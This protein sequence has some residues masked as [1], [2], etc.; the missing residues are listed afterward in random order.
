MYGIRGERQV[1]ERELPWL[2]GHEG[3]SPVRI[4]NAAAE[5]LQLDVFGEVMD[6]L[7]QAR[8]MGL[9]GDP[10]VWA[11][12]RG[13]MDLLEG[14]WQ[15]ADTGLWEVRGQPRHFTHSK[16][17][18]WVAFDRAVTDAERWGLDGPVD[19][20]RRQ[21]DEIRE[22]VL[23]KAWDDDQ[24]TFTQS[25][26]SPHLDASLLLM[27]AVGF[28]PAT[29]ERFSSTVAAI[30]RTLVQDGFVLRY[31][32]S[33]NECDGLPEGE[34]AFLPCSFW[35]VDAYAALGRRDD[36]LALFDRVRGTANDVGLF[37]EQWDGAGGRALG[38]FPQAWSHE[39]FVSSAMN[40]AVGDRTPR[41]QRAR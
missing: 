37:P 10:D 13:L 8:G 30:E 17:M 36:A 14:R 32:T 39:A 40:L 25:Y 41:R 20:W 38:N 12:Q 6:C 15:D 29:D 24:H 1:P 33:T 26:G 23:A 27:P 16:V 34:G 7:G 9:D 35:L 21:R 3:S 5:Q 31:D 28:L 18:A 19:R 2:P 11:M 22:E 4:G